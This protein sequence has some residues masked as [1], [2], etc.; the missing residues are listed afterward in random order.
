MYLFGHLNCKPGVFTLASLLCGPWTPF[1][2]PLHPETARSSSQLS[3]SLG[4]AW[5]L[6]NALRGKWCWVI[7][8]SLC[9]SFLSR[10]LAPQILTALL[11]LWCFQ[12]D[13]LAFHFWRVGQ[14][15]ARLPLS[16]VENPVPPVL[17]T[18]SAAHQAIHIPAPLKR[19]PELPSQTFEI[20]I[21]RDQ[22]DQHQHLIA[23]IKS[24]I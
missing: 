10:I 12:R 18:W 20:S 11:F 14:Q 23:Q 8:S 19:S 1:I 16:E 17:K 3:V 15:Q 9:T 22:R 6:V 7:A 4:A 2:I 24:A 21:Q 5:N 13:F